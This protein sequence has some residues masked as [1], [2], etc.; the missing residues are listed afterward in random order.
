MGNVL[1]ET[2]KLS[3]VI[4]GLHGLYFI[5]N[6]SNKKLPKLTPSRHFDLPTHHSV[7]RTL[8]FFSMLTPSSVYVGAH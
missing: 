5:T 4:V 2:Q 7:N 1:M 3:F 6:L 8:I